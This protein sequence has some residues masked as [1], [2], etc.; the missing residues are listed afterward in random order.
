MVIS[1]KEYKIKKAMAKY[2]KEKEEKEALLKEFMLE[3][4]CLS[5]QKLGED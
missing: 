1:M 4:V 2:K 5:N 3:H